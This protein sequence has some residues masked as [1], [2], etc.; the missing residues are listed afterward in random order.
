MLC[1][2]NCSV[3]ILYVAAVLIL[4]ATMFAQTPLQSSASSCPADR[5]VDDIIAEVQKQQ[6]KKNNRNK[7]P[8]PEVSCVFGWCRSSSK[9][10]PTVKEP[11]PKA[12]SPAD[13][14]T[15]SSRSSA[16]TDKGSGSSSSRSTVSEC[17]NAMDRVLAA[18]H[19]VEV[20]DYYFDQKNYRAA[21]F[22]Y[23]NAAD[24]KQGDAAIYVR[25]GRALEKLNELPKATERYR[26]A[27][28]L[29]SPERW[30][31]EARQALARLEK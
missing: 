11:A 29:G 19:D 25:M 28:Q 5:P 27:E 16:A 14:S 7:N 30:V 3:R 31:Q 10:P 20:G 13:G 22:R 23:Q 12:E 15:S 2:Y 1:C 26:A 18:A 8:F 6:S 24:Q 17:D 4:S 21:L 9:T